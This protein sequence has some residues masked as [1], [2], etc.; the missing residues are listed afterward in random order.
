MRYFLIL[1]SLNQAQCSLRCIFWKTVKTIHLLRPTL[2]LTDHKLYNRIKYIARTDW[3]FHGLSPKTAHFFHCRDHN[4]PVQHSMKTIFKHRYKHAL[5]HTF[6]LLF[7]SKTHQSTSIF[8]LEE[9][10]KLVLKGI[11]R[12]FFLLE[13]L[14]QA[15]CS[16]CYTCLKTV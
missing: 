2:I 6:R 1:G 16:L 10:H 9:V 5:A 14:N 7:I 12:H 8:F 3:A 15:Q 4:A 11:F 13:S